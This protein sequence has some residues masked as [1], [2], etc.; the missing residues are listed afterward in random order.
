MRVVPNLANG[1]F[2]FGNFYAGEVW[3]LLVSPHLHASGELAS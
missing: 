1:C 2:E 3:A